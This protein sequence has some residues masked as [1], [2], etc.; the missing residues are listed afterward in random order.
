[1]I[2]AAITLKLCSYDESGGIVAA[3]TTSIPEAPSSGRNWDYRYC[4]LR[5]A[6]FVVSALNRLGATRTMEG[7]L[8][9]I[10]N[11]VATVQDGYLQPVFG[12]LREQELDE[13]EIA[14]LPGYRAMGPV[15]VGNKAYQQVQNDGYGSVILA[16]T[17]TFF[18]QRLHRM[19][20]AA[21]FERLER[22]GE[23]AIRRW[24]QPD[25]GPW[26]F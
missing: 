26:E 17:Q 23:Q 3:M 2:R 8:D 5:D 19:G 18:D 7:Y 21:L 15:R 24:D 16:C 4:W 14:T 6:Y 11:I 10:A 9:Y 1:V 25:A 22:L 12:L 13:R 20:D